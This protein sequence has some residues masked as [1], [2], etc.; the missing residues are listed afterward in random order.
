MA[1]TGYLGL[2][3][4]AQWTDGGADSGGGKA[5]WEEACD[6]IEFDSAR[7]VGSSGQEWFGGLSVRIERGQHTLVVGGSKQRRAALGAVLMGSGGDGGSAALAGG[8]ARSPRPCSGVAQVVGGRR[9]YVRGGSSLWDLLVFPHDKAQSLRRGVEERHLA[10]LL[11][12][13][14]FGFLLAHVSA[15]WGKVIDWAKVLDRRSCAALA[16]CR[17]LYHAPEFAVVDDDALR[18][19]LPDQV[20]R[21]IAVASMHHITMVVLA[22]ADPFD[23]SPPL[24][25]PSSSASSTPPRNSGGGTS[26]SGGGEA[27]LYACIG[28]FS[29]ALRL[30]GDRF[31]EFCSVGYGPAQRVAFDAGTARKWA[32]APDADDGGL[33]FHSTLRRMPSSLS[34]C[35]T[36][37]RHWLVTPDYPLSPAGAT[38][39]T[40]SALSRR[41]SML[42]ASPALLASPALTARSSLS[43]IATTTS[44]LGSIRLRMAAAAD[45]APP[46]PPT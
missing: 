8:R 5:Q 43:D 42:F 45:S 14:E 34:Q 24:S 26:S 21:V 29:R 4:V 36:T 11:R 10:E 33:G 41:Q 22:E 2:Q 39:R 35:T 6:A 44:E 32:W 37:E 17:I 9:P 7:I 20:R 18:D 27:G 23:D 30:R 46:P 38:E 31:W 15:D 25:P 3:V 40:G 19:L 16:V 28:E 1:E 12:C 13:L